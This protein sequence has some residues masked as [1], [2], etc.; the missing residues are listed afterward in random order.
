MAFKQCQKLLKMHFLKLILPSEKGLP[1]APKRLKPRSFGG[2]RPLDPNQGKQKTN[3]QKAKKSW[4]EEP[5]KW[6]FKKAKIHELRG[7]RPLDPHQGRCPWTPPGAL[8]QAPGPTP[9]WASTSLA[10]LCNYFLFFLNNQVASL[11]TT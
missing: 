11:I 2:L 8:K 5:S 10:T 4:P 1:G 3:K 9:W 6:V 7:L